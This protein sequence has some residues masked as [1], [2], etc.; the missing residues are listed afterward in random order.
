[1]VAV[2]VIYELAID[3]IYDGSFLPLFEVVFKVLDDAKSVDP[4]VALR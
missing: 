4:Q 3:V 2:K 1:M